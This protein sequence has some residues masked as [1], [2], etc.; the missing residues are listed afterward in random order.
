MKCIICGGEDNI[1]IHIG[2]RDVPEINVL[3]CTEC[4]MVFL[5]SQEN[6]TEQNYADGG[7]LKS[8]YVAISDKT[9]DKSWETWIEETAWDDDRRFEAL[10]EVCRDKKILEFG[11][12]NGGF[13]RRI[14]NVSKSATGIELMDDARV[15]IRKEGIDVYKSLSDVQ[16]EK[17]DIVCMFMVI[18]HLN[19]PDEILKQIYDVM[20]KGGIIICETVNS[21]DALISKYKCEKFMDFT[22]WSEHVLLFNSETLEKLINRNGFSTKWNT[23]IQRYSLPNHLY[24]LSSGK[25][26]GH[27]KWKELGDDIL[28]QAY[29]KKLIEERIADT[30]WYEGMKE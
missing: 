21:E 5:D 29:G 11:C 15:N 30:L 28:N 16:C 9:E 26:G 27:I 18:E 4:G 13:L 25:P 2:T 12:G 19:N 22:Y 3:K 24:W 8:S 17:Y 23:Q 1:C 10:K 6:N 7:M 14:K 20:N